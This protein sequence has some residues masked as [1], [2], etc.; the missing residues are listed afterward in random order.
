MN[1]PTAK[2]LALDLTD[3]LELG[4]RLRRLREAKGLTTLEVAEQ[5]LGYTG[6]HAAVS[7]LER[8]VFA[9]VNL[10]HLDTL[11]AFFGTTREALLAGTDGSDT[12]PP[13]FSDGTWGLN[14]VEKNVHHRLRDLRQAV[15]LT[16]SVFGERVGLGQHYSFLEKGETTPRPESLLRIAT[17]FGVSASWLILGIKANVKAPTQALRLRALRLIKGVSRPAIAMAAA[18]DQFAEM[19]GAIRLSESRGLAIPAPLL[20]RLALAFDVPSE[21]LD[22]Q[23]KSIRA[24]EVRL[25]GIT[26]GE[27]LYA[28]EQLLPKATAGLLEQI[29]VTAA[30]GQ[31]SAEDSAW[32]FRQL[33][34]RIWKRQAA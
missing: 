30:M 9:S 19:R 31:L 1:T 15:G 11:A 28:A 34:A 26:P 22:P 17:E 8:G 12:S 33:S 27:A 5:V 16:V 10:A 13:P 23:N 3:R 29:R 2:K 6:S 21:F 14:D 25:D 7:R 18:P 4:A 24:V 32:L 20:A